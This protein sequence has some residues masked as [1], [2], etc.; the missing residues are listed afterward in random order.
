MDLLEQF[1]N[2]GFYL[3]GPYPNGEIGGLLLNV[4]MA[5]L[6]ISISFVFGVVLGYSRLSCRLYIKYPCIAFIE[7]VRSTPLIM[8]IFWFYFFLPYLFGGSVTIFWSAVVSLCVYAASYQAEIVRAGIIAV[9][10]GQ[11]EAALSTGLSRYQSMRHIV[12]PQ[13]FK[14][15]MP[16]F[17]SFF[18]SLFKDTSVTYIIGV[19]ELT[20]AGIIISQRQPDR[21]YAAY[22]S[23]GIGFWVVCFTMS[24]LARRLEK[25]IGVFDMESY[26][27]EA[28]RDEFMLL[29]RRKKDGEV[30]KNAPAC[31]PPAVR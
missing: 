7:I 1:S 28:C 12:L 9:P 6:A 25:R 29:T 16:S 22:M 23:M 18:V 27:T 26:R 24:Q 10:K 11:L 8:I 31:K 15:M 30:I 14:M 13:A 19:I 5:F 2:I 21:I 4:I 20:Q 17:V 3:L